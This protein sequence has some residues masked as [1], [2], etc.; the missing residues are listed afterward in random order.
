MD[1]DSSLNSTAFGPSRHEMGIADEHLPSPDTGHGG[2]D[3][4]YSEISPLA[5]ESELPSSRSREDRLNND[6][7]KLRRI[8][9]ALSTY[10]SALR[11]A[12]TETEVTATSCTAP[13]LTSTD[14]LYHGG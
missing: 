10:M 4:S 11:N 5:D 7:F 1:V 2:D 9:A 12:Q 14:S 3:M 6:I 13:A 8:N